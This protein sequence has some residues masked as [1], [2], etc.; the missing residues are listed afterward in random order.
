VHSVIDGVIKRLTQATGDRRRAVRQHALQRDLAAGLLPRA[1]YVAWLGQLFFV[2]RTLEWHVGRLRATVP[3]IAAVIH[4]RY[5]HTPALASD[6]SYFDVNLHR[7]TALAP[8]QMLVDVIEGVASRAPLALL[9]FAYVLE[10]GKNGG[11]QIA[12]RARLAYR[13]RAGTGV[14]YLDPYGEKQRQRWLDF[15]VD[16]EAV[17][18]EP[19]EI[20]VIADAAGLMLASLVTI[21]D[22]I[23][24]TQ[25]T[26]TLRSSLA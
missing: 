7:T 14:A 25:A 24:A 4:D 2:H 9:G 10:D 22:A 18:F 17:G 26:T 15:M 8:T 12:K 20:A 13:L 5:F 23:V 3:P 16:M 11:R 1:T 6:L 21:M 19:E